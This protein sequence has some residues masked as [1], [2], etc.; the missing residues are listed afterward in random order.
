MRRSTEG[1]LDGRLALRFHTQ[2][3]EE[4]L[5]SLQVVDHDEHVVRP[6]QCHISVSYV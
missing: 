1:A 3:D 6:L 2:L 4:R 5:G